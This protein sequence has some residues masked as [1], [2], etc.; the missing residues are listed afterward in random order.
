MSDDDGDSLPY[1]RVVSDDKPQPPPALRGDRFRFV[2]LGLA[3]LAI[4]ALARV[5]YLLPVMA[6]AFLIVVHE[7]GH[8]FVAK[9]CSMRVERFS[10]GFGPA[11][12]GLKWL[13]KSG[14]QFQIAPLP[15]GGFVEIR[16]M[17]I[18]E[19]VDAEDVHA[20]PNRPAWQ[21]F[22]T[23]FAGPATNYLSAIVLAFG[24]FT[25]HGMPS[26]QRYHT[27]AEVQPDSAALNKLQV[28]DR[29]LAIDGQAVLANEGASITEIISAKKGAPVDL[30]IQRAGAL[31]HVVITP[32]AATDDKGTPIYLLGI[33]RSS[34]ADTVKV[35]VGRSAIAALEFP[36]VTTKMIVTQF[37]KIITREEKADP[38]G[39]KRI[40]EE[41]K[42][43]FDAGW[44]WALQLFM[45][46]SVYL[47]LFNLFPLPALDG[48]RLVFLAYE[49]VTRRRANAKIEAMVHM[50]GI[51]VLFAVMILV[52]L[53]DFGVI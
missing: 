29:I 51:M 17:N 15:F 5:G 3:A 13:T 31:L 9:W 40:V 45:M 4:L 11:I 28:D 24:L 20:Y 41:F 14:T 50:G 26:K 47:G 34:Q 16:G 19:E 49:M 8:Y 7:S 44:L 52:T 12:P 33:K 2:W 35:G 23:I 37:Y 46:L 18:L 43:A 48:G 38:G 36:V 32:K 53:R 21:R 25:C 6:L 42:A 27:V 39:P 22:L 10:I 1:A 30:T